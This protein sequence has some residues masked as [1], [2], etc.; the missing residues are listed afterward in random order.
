MT[1]DR[2]GSGSSAMEL[3]P[4]HRITNIFPRCVRRGR[5][6]SERWG[7]WHHLVLTLAW[8]SLSKPTGLACRSW[9]STPAKMPAWQKATREMWAATEL[10]QGS[11][12]MKGSSRF[13]CSGSRLEAESQSAKHPGKKGAAGTPSPTSRR[14]Q[15]VP[16]V[17]CSQSLL[18]WG[19]VSFPSLPRRETIS[20]LELPW[21][22]VSRDIRTTHNPETALS[23]LRS[24]SDSLKAK[25]NKSNCEDRSTTPCAAAK[26][27][28][29]LFCPFLIASSQLPCRAGHFP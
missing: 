23:Q 10:C 7:T 26:P 19:R 21:Q 3:T 2:N 13:C 18:F 5:G 8:N 4:E 27:V 14:T 12:V 22:E 16:P 15:G 9:H 24:N 20:S 1:V 17:A 28:T 11:T 6:W 25:P 29:S